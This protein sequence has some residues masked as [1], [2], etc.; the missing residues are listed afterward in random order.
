MEIHGDPSRSVVRLRLRMS[1]A[2][3]QASAPASS[4][5]RYRGGG[6]PGPASA[7][8]EGQAVR[9][10]FR[11][12]RGAVKACARASRVA[13]AAPRFGDTAKTWETSTPVSSS[14]PPPPPGS[15]AHEQARAATTPSTLGPR[16]L[17]LRPASAPPQAA[18]SARP[19]ASSAAAKKGRFVP[20]EVN[21]WLSSGGAR[22]RQ[23]AGGRDPVP[24]DFDAR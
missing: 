4:P 7:P 14:A 9:A 10:T 22:S 21:S 5:T 17:L 8:P 23:I 18:A 24:C 6:A 16:P 12:L 2:Q 19:A 15:G 11:G 1:A 13:F 3:A 20:P